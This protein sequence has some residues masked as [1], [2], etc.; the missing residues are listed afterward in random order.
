MKF[1]DTNLILRYLTK[2]DPA[3]AK[4]CEEL[5]KRVSE[6]KE[7][8]YTS[9]LVIAEV[10]W[11]LEKFYKFERTRAALYIQIILNTSGLECDEKDILLT[12]IGLYDLKKIDFIDAYNAVIMESKSIETI[13]SYDFHF[14]LIPPLKRI[15]P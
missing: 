7:A 8:L 12:A 9:S 1:L 4:K 11:T 2:D 13:Y 3:K 15:E 10:V 6:G 5:F 14:D